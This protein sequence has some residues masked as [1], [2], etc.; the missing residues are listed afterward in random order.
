MDRF[1]FSAGPGAGAADED[2]DTAGFFAEAAQV[3]AQKGPGGETFSAVGE[4][5]RRLARRAGAVAADELESLHGSGAASKILAEGADGSVLM[6]A[7]FPPDVPTPV[8]NHNSWGVV[9]VIDGRDR[10]V[11]WRRTDDGSDPH[12]AQVEIVEERELGPG[13]VVWF[14]G[15]PQDI[16]SQQGIGGDV[17]ELVY[18]GRN[19]N[20][21]PRAYFDPA[22]GALTYASAT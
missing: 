2:L 8:H 6:L 7:R 4:L 12:R 13:D 10:Y 5:M 19:P 11:A 15:P 18:F 21:E 3:V 9:C 1:R 20:L 16:H 22:S 14:E 17:W